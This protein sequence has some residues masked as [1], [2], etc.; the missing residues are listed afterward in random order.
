MNSAMLVR[1]AKSAVAAVIAIYVAELLQ[2]TSPFSAGL[3]AVLG[4]DMTKRRG[5]RSVFV[6]FLASALGLFVASAA[7]LFLGFHIWVIGIYLLVTYPVLYKFKLQDGIVTSCVVILHLFADKQVTFSL[8]GNEIMLLAVGLGT[9]AAINMVYM[10]NSY[11]LLEK[12]KMELEIAFSAIFKEIAAHLVDPARV[13]DGAELLKAADT[14]EKGE[15]LAQRSVEN[16]LFQADMAWQRYFSMRRQHF[17]SVQRMLDLVSQ[18]YQSLPH[19]QAVSRLFDELSRDVQAPHYTGKV[20]GNLAELENEFKRMELPG[21]RQEFEARSALLQLCL[22]L[23][24]FLGVSKA[25]KAKKTD[26]TQD[27]EPAKGH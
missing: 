1:V 16:A 24:T 6:R 15:A 23:R 4:I 3:M 26:G 27:S 17:Q 18:V 7:F 10:P 20:E 13:W 25:M 22:E 11:H 2:L 12:V 5:M 21:T 14:L 8:I 19:G 9:A